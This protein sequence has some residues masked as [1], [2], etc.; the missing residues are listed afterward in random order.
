MAKH[1]QDIYDAV[2]KKKQLNE[3]N[4]KQIAERRAQ[5]QKLVEIDGVFPERLVWH[6]PS[7]VRSGNPQTARHEVQGGP[8]LQRQNRHGL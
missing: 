8:G 1:A 4:E 5:E 2:E 7:S 3:K 6:R